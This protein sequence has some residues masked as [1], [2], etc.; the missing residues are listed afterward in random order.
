M[1]GTVRRNVYL[2][3]TGVVGVEPFIPGMTSVMKR[4]DSS[5]DEV[6]A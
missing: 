4:Q 1:A 6:V 3:S 5:S 2:S